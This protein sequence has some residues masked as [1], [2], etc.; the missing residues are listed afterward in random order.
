MLV[1]V[2]VDMNERRPHRSA[3]LLMTMSM[4]PDSAGRGDAGI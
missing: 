4:W 1:S 3:G 2:S